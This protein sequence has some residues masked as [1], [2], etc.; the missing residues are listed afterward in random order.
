[1][2]TNIDKLATW[3]DWHGYHDAARAVPQMFDRGPSQRAERLAEGALA[4]CLEV[5]P[6]LT[7]NRA[8]VADGIELK[9]G[10][11]ILIKDYFPEGPRVV[12]IP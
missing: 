1:V 9:P 4:K 5:C 11:K 10:D 2:K 3:L 6:H 7:G 12:T 8:S